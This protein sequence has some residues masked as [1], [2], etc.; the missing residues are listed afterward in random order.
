MDQT[1]K[2]GQLFFFGFEG[3][4]PDERILQLIRDFAL[5]GVIL[6]SRN[7]RDP[8]Q[9]AELV[10]RLQA[11]AKIPLFVGIDQEGGRVCRLTDH[12]TRFPGNRAL[13]KAGSFELARAFGRATGE[14]LSA[15]GVN[16][17][18]AP[19]LDVDSNPS[20]P[21]IGNRSFGADPGLVGQLG[22]AVIQGLEEKGVIACGKHF[23]GHGDTALDSH[24]ALPEVSAPLETLRQRE[25]VPFVRALGCGLATLMTA[26]VSYRDLDPTCPA[27]LSPKIID[28]ILRKELGFTGV[29][30]SDDLEMRAV[31]EHFGIEASAVRA[32]NAGVDVLLICKDGEKQ[33]KGLAAVSKAVEKGEIPSQ[34]VDEAVD[35]V[36]TLKRGRLQKPFRTDRDKIEQ[37]LRSR[38]NLELAATIQDYLPA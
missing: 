20:N 2:I 14:E 25:L 15:I 37:T 32:I 36:L 7:I 30:F 5:G 24:L 29:L 9:T 16:L 22:C 21:I 3:L 8:L 19:V 12:F 35:R 6:F 18:F 26:H 11:E 33:E 28:H 10:Q 17:D 23:P 13:G 27:T 31:D 34:R 4:E 38:K 1:R